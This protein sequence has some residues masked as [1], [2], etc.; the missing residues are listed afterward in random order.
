MTGETSLNQYF[1]K[2]SAFSLVDYLGLGIKDGDGLCWSESLDILGRNA[3][4]RKKEL[5]FSTLGPEA[6][7]WPSQIL[8]SSWGKFFPCSTPVHILWMSFQVLLPIFKCL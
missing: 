3:P 2:E 4:T 6:A 7:S 5:V 8:L 1:L